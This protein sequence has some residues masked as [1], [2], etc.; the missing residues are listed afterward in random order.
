MEEMKKFPN[1]FEEKKGRNTFYF[2][3]TNDKKSFFEERVISKKG[4]L[5]R[6]VD[7]ERSKLFASIAK[8]ISQLGIKQDSKVL[9]LGASHGYTVSFLADVVCDGEIYALDFAPRVVRDL[10]FLCE[11]K[12]NVAPI[13][14]DAN[15][16][17][18]YKEIVPMVDVVFMD[19]AQ[20]EQTKIF[21]K[22]CDMYLKEGGFGILAL[23]ARSIDVTRNPKDIFRITRSQLDVVMNVVDYRELAPFEQDHAVFVCKRKSSEPIDFLNIPSIVVDQKKN[24]LPRKEF[25]KPS[26]RKRY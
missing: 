9:Y 19:I 14:D 3:R 11:D 24:F 17:E 16:P 13:L 22:N 4:E 25:S 2:I 18:N 8:G 20:R 23:K 21:L 26:F 12:K 1:V 6:E 7:P 10:V 15:H 5:F